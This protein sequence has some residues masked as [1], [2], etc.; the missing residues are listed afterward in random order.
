MNKMKA[1]SNYITEK[2]KIDKD[3]KVKNDV[4]NVIFKPEEVTSLD[5]MISVI[6]AKDCKP[7]IAVCMIKNELQDYIDI[8]YPLKIGSNTV[9]CGGSTV[10][11]KD[12]NVIIRPATSDEIKTWRKAE[13]IGQSARKAANTVERVK[14]IKWINVS[15]SMG[16]K[17]INFLKP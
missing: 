7:T 2:L 4:K 12:N 6:S 5:Q 1:I 15:I 10:R 8:E 13:G 9:D 14:Q 3:S 11:V 17:F 16:E